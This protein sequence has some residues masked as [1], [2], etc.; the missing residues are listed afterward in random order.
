VS[1]TGNDDIVNFVILPHAGL[2][3]DR[4]IRSYEF[5]MFSFT[6]GLGFVKTDHVLDVDAWFFEV[7]Q[8]SD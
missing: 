6:A 1:A 7:V 2:I 3:S 4:S 5:R 8:L